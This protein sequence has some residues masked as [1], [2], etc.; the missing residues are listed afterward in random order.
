MDC[1]LFR[2][3]P[4]QDHEDGEQHAE[5]QLEELGSTVKHRDE[6]GASVDI[7][8]DVDD[9]EEHGGG[10]IGRNNAGTSADKARLL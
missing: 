10:G 8:V 7:G 4:T 3:T 2:P 5:I 1:P 9:E 6:P